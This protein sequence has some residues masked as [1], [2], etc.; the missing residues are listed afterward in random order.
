MAANSSG[1]PS[2]Q[3]LPSADPTK[4]IDDDWADEDELTDGVP[5]VVASKAPSTAPTKTSTASAAASSEP[6]PKHDSEAPATDEIDSDWPD[7]DQAVAQPKIPKQ[8]KLP[9][10]DGHPVAEPPVGASP[11]PSPTT[12]K[13]PSTVPPTSANFEQAAARLTEE[14]TL[15]DSWASHKASDRPPKSSGAASEPPKESGDEEAL[16]RQAV[17]STDKPP[18]S[19]RTDKKRSPLLGVVVA[20]AAVALIGLALRSG[21]S[22]KPS[23]DQNPA[24]TKTVVQPAKEPDANKP[25]ADEAKADA[26]VAEP[27]GIAEGEEARPDEAKSPDENKPAGKVLVQLAIT[28]L[29]AEIYSKGQR[30]GKGQIRVEVDPNDKMVL[31]AVREGYF[32]RKVVLDGS[33]PYVNVGMRLKPEQEGPAAEPAPPR[34]KPAT[35]APIKRPASSK[36]SPTRPP[37]RRSGAPAQGAM[38]PIRR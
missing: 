4:D 36:P 11:Q 3:T 1:K 28:P 18:A 20:A 13:S 24:T 14:S 31:L 34:P 27:K 37:E 33:Q 38:Q 23:P 26:K 35:Q 5:T 21:H 6:A 8:A 22:T 15:S 17:T 32:P 30:L 29:D 9:N 19:A 10:I 7:E 16:A 2:E 12:T 25:S